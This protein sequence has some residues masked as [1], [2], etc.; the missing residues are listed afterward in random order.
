MPQIE[1]DLRAEIQSQLQQEYQARLEEEIAKTKDD[2]KKELEIIFAEI[3]EQTV[4]SFQEKLDE[5]E[6]QEHS[7]QEEKHAMESRIRTQIE[8]DLR[9][10]YE[11]EKELLA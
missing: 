6:S 8:S 11:K 4:K 10:E 9:K 3:Q 5:L 1:N 7:L 2:A